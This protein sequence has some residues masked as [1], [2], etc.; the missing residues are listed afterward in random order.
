MADKKYQ[1]RYMGALDALQH[2]MTKLQYNFQRMTWTD[3]SAEDFE[4][5]KLWEDN[6]V[7][8]WE[9]RILGDEPVVAKVEEPKKTTKK[10]TAKKSTAKKTASKKSTSKKK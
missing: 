1:V 7:A 5:Y 3:V 4:N 2:K 8:D 6:G 9:T 10:S